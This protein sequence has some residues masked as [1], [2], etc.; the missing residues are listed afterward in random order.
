MEKGIRAQAKHTDVENLEK[1]MK[2]DKQQTA[3]Y[4]TDAVP[5]EK[6]GCSYRYLQTRQQH[7]QINLGQENQLLLHHTCHPLQSQ[8]HEDLERHFLEAGLAQVLGSRQQT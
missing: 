3:V 1:D 7:Q 5:D 8:N 4:D 2:S 6:P